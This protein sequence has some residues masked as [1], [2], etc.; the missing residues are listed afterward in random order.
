[1]N[2]FERFLAI[3]RL[4]VWYFDRFPDDG[5]WSHYN[6]DRSVEEIEAAFRVG[7]ERLSIIRKAW[8]TMAGLG[9]HA[10]QALEAARYYPAHSPRD[11][12]IDAFNSGEGRLYVESMFNAGPPKP[13]PSAFNPM[14]PVGRG[15]LTSLAM[16]GAGSASRDLRLR[17][18]DDCAERKWN[19][20][21]VWLTWSTGGIIDVNG[22]VDQRGLGQLTLL[23]LEAAKRGISLELRTNGKSGFV[24]N[25]EVLVGAWERILRTIN[26]APP[27]LIDVLNEATDDGITTN[28]VVVLTQAVRAAAQPGTLVTASATG[29]PDA[30]VGRIT[31]AYR[32]W[33][34]NGAE[35]DFYAPHEFRKPDWPQDA[36]NATEKFVRVINPRKLL[37]P[38]PIFSD[39]PG[40]GGGTQPHQRSD[41][42]K[43][44]AQDWRDYL[45]GV[46]AG[47]GQGANLMGY[48]GFDFRDG[49]HFLE[50]MRPEERDTFHN[51]A[52][53]LGW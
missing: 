32:E 19:N 2:G 38:K 12:R 20:W 45:L 17:M 27:V 53:W 49:R 46:R 47:G 9:V 13:E 6:S 8:E 16:Y 21:V 28:N 25:P 15:Y 5:I 34:D 42:R 35:I 11:F 52:T 33:L 50:Q 43:L 10:E 36:R 40:H 44:D 37:P 4:Y 14:D 26:D 7:P 1:M 39:E 24:R 30:G 18:L 51:A 41:P 29:S 48:Y 23:I 3:A 31:K 22:T